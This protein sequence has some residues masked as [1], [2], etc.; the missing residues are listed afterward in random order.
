MD[1]YSRNKKMISTHE[2]K[3]LSESTVVILGMGGLGGYAV[4]MLTRI[5]V[6][7][8]ILV[9]FDKFEMSN[10]NRQII[11]TEDNLGISKVEEG[12][13]RAETINPETEV[14]AINRKISS[15]NIDAIIK[16][17]DIVVDALDSPGLKKIVELSCDKNNIPMVHGAIGGWIAQVAVIMPGDFILDK[18]YKEDDLENKMGNPS[19]TPA[20]AASIQVGEVIKL[21]LNKGEVL[22]N[23]VLYI[24]LEYN[25]FTRLKV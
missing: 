24:D 12:K 6:G 7:K 21:L 22:N 5:G 19:F 20:L 8:L 17:A 2:Q 15:H 11:S 23:E 14:M 18:I 16:G 10:L 13:K 3:K 4:E 9:D 1:R 25:S